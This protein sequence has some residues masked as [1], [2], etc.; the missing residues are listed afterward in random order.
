[1]YGLSFL[2]CV[3][4]KYKGTSKFLIK[5]QVV[6]KFRTIICGDGLKSCT[7]VRKQKPQCGVK[8]GQENFYPLYNK[9]GI[10]TNSSF[11]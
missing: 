10:L 6:G 3:Q 2:Q 4:Y 9:R 7:N 8:I 5:E 11:Q 1:M